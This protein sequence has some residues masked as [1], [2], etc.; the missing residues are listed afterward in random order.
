MKTEL[1]LIGFGNMGKSIC[2]LILFNS[3]YNVAIVEKNINK[4]DSEVQNFWSHID[5]LHNK[6][7]CK[8]DAAVYK[9]RINFADKIQPL[10]INQ[11]IVIEAIS[12]DIKTKQ[13][14]FHDLDKLYG[15]YTLFCSN[16]SN[17][18][19]DEIFLKVNDKSRC[20]GV[21]FFN[22]ADRLPVVEVG[23]PAN[24]KQEFREI[25]SE[26]FTILK[27]TPFYFTNPKPGYVVNKLIDAFL[28]IAVLEFVSSGIKNDEFDMLVKKALGH[29]MGPLQLC[30]IIGLDILYKNLL[31]L[32][33][34]YKNSYYKPN[35]IIEKM[36]KNQKIGKKSKEGFYKYE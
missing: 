12:E 17:L 32:F 19:L 27:I 23:C 15:K 1:L 24:E 22:P 25:L 16:T 13:L 21:H 14:I 4:M 18:P 3:N 8:F 2:R 36:V 35:E 20:Y 9:K 29:P 26:F 5:R 6:G 31:D 30:D 10:F 28:N 34:V 33:D 11:K 7:I